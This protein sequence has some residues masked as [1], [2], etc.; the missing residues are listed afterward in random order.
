MT[1]FTEGQTKKCHICGEP[2]FEPEGKTCVCWKCEECGEEFSDFDMLANRE[3]WLCLYCEDKRYQ[4]EM[5]DEN[6]RSLT[7]S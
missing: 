6:E 5:R 3:L 1:D 4:G 7:N 2:Y